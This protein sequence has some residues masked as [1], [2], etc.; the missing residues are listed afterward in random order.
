MTEFS[1]A[2]RTVY[3]VRAIGTIGPIKIGATNALPKRLAGMDSSSPYP[4]ECIAH[5]D[6]SVDIERRLHALLADHHERKEWFRWSPQLA[7]VIAAI[8]GGTFD[9]DSL[10]DPVCIAGRGVRTKAYHAMLSSRIAA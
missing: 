4:L 5:F 9:F 6:G 2:P 10:P 1:A 7:S 8:R 3:F